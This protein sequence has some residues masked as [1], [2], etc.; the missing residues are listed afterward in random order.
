MLACIPSFLSLLFLAGS[1]SAQL[2]GSVGPL[3]SFA[4]KA[5]NKV[6]DITDYGAVANSTED[7]G[8]AL[9]A[10]WDDCKEGGLVYVPPGTYA[11]ATWVSLTHGNASAVQLDGTIYRDGDDGGHMISFR[12]CTDF[13]FFSGNSQ[14]ALQG[15]GYKLLQNG[16]YG[17]RFLR[18]TDVSNFSV[19]GFAMV[20][21][22]SYYSVFDSCS[23]GEIYNIII[24]GIQIGATDGV[25]VWGENLWVHDVEV[26][27]GDECVTVKSPAKN[28][29]I[30][31]IHCNLSGGTAIGSLGTNTNISNVHYRNLYMN[32]A[33]ACYLKSNGGN[34]TVS[35]I[36]WENVLIHG[37][38]YV[39]AVNENWESR[40]EDSGDGVQISNL[41]FKDWNGFN[42]DNSRPTI[43]IECA[44]EV[45]C[46]DITL[47]NVN[48]WTEDGDYV[49]WSCQSAYGEGACLQDAGD[50]V[51]NLASYSTAQTVTQTP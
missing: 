31:S 36:M 45:P 40:D 12:D 14:G 32:Q 6:C 26:S 30:E 35:D 16:E 11:M 29:L 47:D 13:E 9:A 51:E 10:A 42:T 27:N 3:T 38:A 4:T 39:L 49:T 17:A 2:S 24:R 19:H 48:L 46:Y 34:G 20:D 41:T 5:S 22:A 15:Y 37:G 28:F 18:F 7:V 44:D 50:D 33:D 8:P 1:T 25:D 21:S 23:N 43:R